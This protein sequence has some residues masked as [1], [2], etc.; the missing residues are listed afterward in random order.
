LV[1]NIVLTS[2]LKR[3]GA[4]SFLVSSTEGDEIGPTQPV[5]R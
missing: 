1:R 2:Q 3:R 4:A 5:T